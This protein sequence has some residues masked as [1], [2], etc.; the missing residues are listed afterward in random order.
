[1]VTFKKIISALTIG[2]LVA[3]LFTV[4]AFAATGSIYLTPTSSSI[5]IGNAETL[6]LRINPG[7]N[8]DGVQATVNF[9]S[10]NLRL[11][12]VDTSSSPFS[13]TLQKTIGSN[14]VTLAVGTLVSG[15][16]SSDS[17]IATLNFTAL[18]S[19]GSS[20]LTVTNANATS[21]GSYTNPSASGATVSFT[22]APSAPAPVTSQP[23]S[24]S[25]HTSTTSVATPLSPVA[26]PAL[27]P[28]A[29]AQITAKVSTVSLTSATILVASDQSVT[30]YAVYGS[31]ASHLTSKTD[32]TPA[33][34]HA[35]ITIGSSSSSLLPGTEYYYQIVGTND[36]G[37]QSTS[38]LQHFT[39]TGITVSVTVLDQYNHPLKRQQV[40]LH[41]QPQTATTNDAGVATFTNIAPGEHHLLYTATSGKKY[42]ATVYVDN[43]TTTV[44]TTTIPIQ[45]A[46]VILAVAPPTNQRATIIIAIV[47]LAFIGIIIREIYKARRG[48]V[49]GK[50]LVIKLVTVKPGTPLPSKD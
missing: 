4:Q 47:V 12:S 17:L 21:T 15:G 42:G 28:A 1:M 6:S 30:S 16:I 50:H 7:T 23:K 34:T 11:N 36:A 14:S 39:T 8:V 29:L 22:A 5:Q 45:H 19:S 31:D 48:A 41:S 32:S 26:T 20:S 46:A 38:T 13:T 44:N 33:G 40:T 3:P 25:T 43:T 2:T 9:N 37:Q 18:T 24:T 49:L 10:L 27:T 35:T